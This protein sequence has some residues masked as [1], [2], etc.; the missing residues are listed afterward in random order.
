[1]SVVA[2]IMMIVGIFVMKKMVK[3]EV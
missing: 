3:I 2:G 1:M